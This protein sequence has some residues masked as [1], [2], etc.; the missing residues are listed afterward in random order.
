MRKIATRVI[1]QNLLSSLGLNGIDIELD[2]DEREWKN[3]NARTR[4]TNETQVKRNVS[5]ESI[6]LSG[7]TVLVVLLLLLLLL[8]LC[9]CWWW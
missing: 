1:L 8:L 6:G 2:I 5:K 4:L 7:V 9:C 3:N